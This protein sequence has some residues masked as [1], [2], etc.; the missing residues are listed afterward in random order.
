MQLVVTANGTALNSAS[1]SLQSTVTTMFADNT[2]QFV[3]LTKSAGQY[4]AYVNGIQ[5]LQGTIDNTAFQNQNL[6]IGN[7][8]G[9]S[10]TLINSVLMNKVN[11]LLIIFVLETE[12]LFLQFLMMLL[13]ILLQVSLVKDLHG[14]IHH[15]S[16]LTLTNM[17]ISI[18]LVGV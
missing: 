12:Q 1:G 14:L 17:I 2:W 11:T 7:I 5:V 16:L 8:P 6:Y 9:K 18:M 3:A 10:G 13:T 15:G 4:T